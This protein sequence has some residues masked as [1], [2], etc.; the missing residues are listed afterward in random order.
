[1]QSGRA[2][3]EEDEAHSRPHSKKAPRPCS[4]GRLE[5]LKRHSMGDDQHQEAETCDE[6]EFIGT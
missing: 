1:M 3:S 2:E 6:T 5:P 4:L